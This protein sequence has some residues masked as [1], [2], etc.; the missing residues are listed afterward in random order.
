LFLGGLLSGLLGSRT[1]R[2]VGDH[3][4]LV[5]L[6][7]LSSSLLPLALVLDGV[8]FDSSSLGDIDDAHSGL[9]ESGAVVLEPEHVSGSSTLGRIRVLKKSSGLL[10][11]LGSLRGLGDLLGRRLL[12][13]L[14]C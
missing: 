14:S 5:S 13:C 7:V 12:D 10:G 9:G 3:F 4:L 8:P 1:S 11:G 2:L 6:L